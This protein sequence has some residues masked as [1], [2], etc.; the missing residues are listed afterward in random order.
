MCDEH[1]VIAQ[2]YSEEHSV[3][4]EHTVQHEQ[5]VVQVVEQKNIVVHE[6]VV[7]VQ[8]QLDIMQIR[9]VVRRLVP[10]V[11]HRILI[12]QVMQVVIV[13][14]GSVILIIYQNEVVL[15]R[16]QIIG[17]GDSFLLV[18]MMLIHRMVVRFVINTEA[19]L[20]LRQV[21][22][23]L[24]V[25][26]HIINLIVQFS[27]LHICHLDI[28]IQVRIQAISVMLIEIFIVILLHYYQITLFLR[29]MIEHIEQK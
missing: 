22:L 25:R 23:I 15:V 7:V 1:I 10:I 13:V 29:Q 26:H 27:M 12:I 18:L 8:H 14:V 24:G 11:S 20:I 5:V 21:D 6:Q 4:V 19:A 9:R 2:V 28:I 3:V 17:N 16:H